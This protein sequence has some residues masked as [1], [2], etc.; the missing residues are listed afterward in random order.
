[1]KELVVKEEQ[2]LFS[3]L[4]ENISGSK[5]NIKSFLTK[6]LVSV[7]GKTVTQYNYLLKVNDKVSIGATVVVDRDNLKKII[8]GRNGS[9][10]K[11]IGTLARED[12]EKLLDK[13]V[14]LD[15]FVKVIPK[16]RDREKYLN[17]TLFKEFNFD[18]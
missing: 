18:K 14:Y 13:S 2:E 6:Q 1:M 3:F 12:I 16:W 5:N 4:K 17:E 11:E 10:I 15:L 7:N 9:M 8:I